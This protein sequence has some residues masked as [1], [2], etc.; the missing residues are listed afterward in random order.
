MSGEGLSNKK[1]RSKDCSLWNDDKWDFQNKAAEKIV[2]DCHNRK[3][4]GAL[5]GAAVG[6]GKTIILMHAINKIVNEMPNSKI[7]FLAHGQK[8]LKHQTLQTFANPPKSV[9]VKF[10]FGTVNDN[11]QVHVAIPQEFSKNMK[12]EKYSH[13]IA[14]EAHEWMASPTVLNKIL[15]RLKK[16]KLILATGSISLFN[17]YNLRYPDRPFAITTVSG[18]EMLRRGI[19]NSVTL[20]LIRIENQNCIEQKLSRFITK[21]KFDLKALDKPV[22]VCNSIVESQKASQ[23]MKL[24]GYLVSLSTSESDPQ[25]KEIANF[26]N[27]V[28]NCLILVDRGI[29]GLNIPEASCMFFLKKTKNIEIIQQALARLF[30]K[31]KSGMTKYFYAPAT[32]EEWNQKIYLLQNVLSLNS[33]NV[34]TG[35]LGSSR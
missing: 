29:L 34:M 17:R 21:A 31:S 12:L 4:I 3:F 9:D 11:A 20:D 2:S 8:F 33:H 27:E 13:V 32:F 5:I 24:K 14:D 26:K 23:F 35:F 19:Y 1:T 16:P 7:L 6:S 22:I 25:S 30:R 15:A 10:S 18:D 28:T